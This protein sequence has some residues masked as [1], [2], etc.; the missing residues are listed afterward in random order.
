VYRRPSIIIVPANLVHAWER[1]V[2][3]LIPQTGLTLIN[4]FS[5]RQLT[6]NDLNYSSD[7][8]EGSKAIHLISYSAYRA[9]CNNSEPL[10]GCNWG[11][12]IFDASHTAKSRVTE[13]FDSLMKI[14][15]P[16]RIQPT[17]TPMHHTVGDWVVQTEWL[18]AQVTDQAELDSHGPRPLDSAIA[19]AKRENITLEEAYDQIKDIAW[20]WTIRRWGETKDANGEPLIRIPELVQ[21]DVRLQYTDDQATARDGWI[22]NT[23]GDK[24]NAIQTVPHEWCL[25]CLTMDLPENDI[26]SDDSES[27]DTAVPYRESWVGHTFRGGPVF[28]WFSYVFVPQLLGTPE[29]GV[30]NNVVIFTPLPGQAS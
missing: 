25:A 4:L 23:K 7:N 18:F 27:I 8:P 21:H 3:S 6:Y 5:R 22:E 16:C 30:P 15:V 20:P 13:T 1:A 11:V 29:G 14:D 12:G 9:R 2:Q 10:R 26:S 28:R 24:W 19:D 17:G